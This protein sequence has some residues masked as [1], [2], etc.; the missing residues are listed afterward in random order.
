MTKADA[1]AAR[2]PAAIRSRKG[3]DVEGGREDAG[4]VSPKDRERGGRPVADDAAVPLDV[5][6]AGDSQVFARQ[7]QAW[8]EQIRSTR[9]S[10][11]LLEAASGADGHVQVDNRLRLSQ[12]CV[13]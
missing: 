11:V 3:V 6:G 13:G 4:G 5:R 10:F 7:A 1:K 2:M 9:K 12:E 8:H